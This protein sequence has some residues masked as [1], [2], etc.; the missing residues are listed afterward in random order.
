MRNKTCGAFR[1]MLAL[2]VFLFIPFLIGAQDEEVP[3]SEGE[4][5]ISQSVS[6]ESPSMESPPGEIPETGGEP[7]ATLIFKNTKIEMIMQ[8]LKKQTGVNVVLVGKVVNDLRIDFVAQNEPV[9]QILQKIA[10]SKNLVVV[11]N[12]S[13]NYELMDEATYNKER[14]PKMAQR[15]IFILKH[16][17]AEDARKALQNV[18]TKGIGQMAA[19]PRTNKLIITD[20]PQVIE[21]IKRL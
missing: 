5:P 9:S 13:M 3:P 7:V 20:L 18:L 12:D 6:E 15:K 1:K 14:L 11:R 2:V 17:K 10:S 19:D 21:L 8:S 4:P 16:I